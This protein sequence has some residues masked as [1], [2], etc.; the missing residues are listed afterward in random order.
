MFITRSIDSTAKLFSKANKIISSSAF[1]ARQSNK[2]AFL[3]LDLKCFPFSR[4]WERKINILLTSSSRLVRG[5]SKLFIY[6][7][8]ETIGF[9]S[10]DERR[11]FSQRR[12]IR[13]VW[14]SHGL[15]FGETQS[16]QNADGETKPENDMPPKRNQIRF[17]LYAR[18]AFIE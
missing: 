8:Y 16:S 15:Y 10:L 7:G 14:S 18:T 5:I 9:L 4:A 13:K 1:D 11:P 6:L 3:A 2:N 12:H 17:N